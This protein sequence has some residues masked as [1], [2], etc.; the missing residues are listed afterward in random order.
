MSYY[1]HVISGGKATPASLF[2]NLNTGKVGLVGTRDAV[3][4]DEIANTDFTDP[5]SMVSIMQGYMQDAKFSR[6]KKEI[7]AFSSIVLVG[8]LDVQGRLPHEKYYHLFE[9]LPSYLQVEAFID[10]LHYYLSGWEVPKIGP[11]SASQDYG[12]ITDYFYAR[13]CTNYA[14]WTCWAA[15]RTALSCLMRPV[16]A[17]V[18]PRAMCAPC[19]RLSLACSS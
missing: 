1:A 13:S 11:E 7:L 15:S 19:T 12:F 17:R 4:F 9:P 6:G 16:P 3:V 10:R 14:A 8:N 2:I 18:S 5:K